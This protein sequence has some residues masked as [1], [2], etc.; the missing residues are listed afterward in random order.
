VE[1]RRHDAVDAVETS[2]GFEPPI[3][4]DTRIRCT[5]RAKGFVGNAVE[6]LLGPGRRHWMKSFGNQFIKTRTG[7]AIQIAKPSA[8]DELLDL[9]VESVGHNQH[10][11]SFL[12]ARKTNERDNKS[13]HDMQEIVVPS[14]WSTQHSRR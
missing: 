11:F 1:P 5:A 3:F 12:G 10:G 14:F 13:S 6:K 9:A 7:P 8:A 4:A 2:R